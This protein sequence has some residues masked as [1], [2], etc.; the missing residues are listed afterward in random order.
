[1][2]IPRFVYRCHYCN[3]IES[4]NVFEGYVCFLNCL[5]N[6]ALL[7]VLMEK[8]ASEPLGEFMLHL[9]STS[10]SILSWKNQVLCLK[11]TDRVQVVLNL[12]P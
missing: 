5:S 2:E 10:Y 7:Q 1:M 12:Q 3:R 11:I 4:E 9:S 8:G 6:K